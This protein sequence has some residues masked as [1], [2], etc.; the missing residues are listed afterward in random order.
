MCSKLISGFAGV[1]FT[2]VIAVTSSSA[3]SATLDDVMTR[4]DKLEKE[5]QSIKKENTEL[6]ERMRTI[7]V[8]RSSPAAPTHAVVGSTA[9]QTTPASGKLYNTYLPIKAPPALAPAYSW[10]GCYVGATA[11]FA[12]QHA[13]IEEFGQYGSW[14][15]W[16]YGF[17]GGGELGCNLQ[18]DSFVYGIEGDFSGLTNNGTQDGGYYGLGKEKLDWLATVRLRSGLD[19]GKTLV[20]LTYGVAFGHVS[21]SWCYYGS[22][23]Y[24]YYC[25]PSYSSYGNY[26]VPSGS[27]T[28]V[29]WVVGAGLARALTDNW[30]VKIEALY[31]DLGDHTLCD[32]STSTYGCNNATYITRPTAHDS[33]YIARVGVDYK[34][35]WGNMGKAP[36]VSAKD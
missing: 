27:A 33:A 26:Y 24:T 4:L 6:R 30:S 31:V 29:G 9:P 34:F 10:A 19:V 12:E 11:G 1:V 25:N 36:V 28:K 5:N 17:I 18:Y 7:E 35:D 22:A 21:D 14:D 32:G 16:S 2:S 15:G 20:Y 23:G 13:T 3:M 8:K